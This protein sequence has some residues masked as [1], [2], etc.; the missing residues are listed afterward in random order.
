[1]KNREEKEIITHI[2]VENGKLS[3]INE[4]GIYVW[5]ES[6]EEAFDLV[7]DKVNEIINYLNSKNQNEGE[8]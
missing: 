3:T 4:D 1:M 8:E 7:L 6:F 5:S 2:E